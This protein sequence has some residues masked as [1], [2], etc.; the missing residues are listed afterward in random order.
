MNNDTNKTNTTG[1]TPAP[2]PQ[3]LRRLFINRTDVLWKGLGP[4]R[5]TT[6]TLKDDRHLDRLLAAHAAEKITVGAHSTS[7]ENTCRW[8]GWDLASHTSGG[9]SASSGSG[10]PDRPRFR[11]GTGGFCSL[12]RDHA[13]PIFPIHDSIAATEPRT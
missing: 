13:A 7:A 3:L 12:V 2:L 8:A 5:S 11:E 9:M 10:K 1:G 4:K 6:V